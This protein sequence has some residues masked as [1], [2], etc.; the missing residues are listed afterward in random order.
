MK[1]TPVQ[2]RLF[3][4]KKSERRCY[5]DTRYFFPPCNKRLENEKGNYHANFATTMIVLT[6]VD[7]W[8]P[9]W[10]GL[11]LRDKRLRALIPLRRS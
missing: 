4:N 2:E 3:K 1:R 8:T 7:T 9:S 10:G 5:T 6:N 11:Y